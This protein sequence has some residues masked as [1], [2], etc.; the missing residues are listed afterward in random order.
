MIVREPAVAGSFYSAS[1]QRC[2]KEVEQCI[3]KELDVSALPEVIF[4]GIVP[5]AG[6]TFSGPVAGQVFAAIAAR[7]QPATF[8]VFG[9]V[10]RRMGSTAAIFSSGVWETPLGAIETDQRLAERIMSA[11]SLIDDDPYAHEME[12][13]IE[14]QVP[15]IQ[16]LFPNARLVAI[17]VQPVPEAVEV[18]RAV[19]STIKAYDADAVVV[20]STDLTHYGPRYGFAPKGV[21]EAGVRWAKE[22][23]DRRILD[24]ILAM[25]A[26]AIVPEAAEHMNACGAGAAAATV[27]ACRELGATRGYLLSHVSSYEVAR[28]LWG[29]SSTD[30]VGYA[31][32]V[33][34]S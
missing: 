19:A 6:W 9:A 28:R 17:M 27:A 14:V 1:P 34:G 23:N 21:G 18:G 8:V 2:R 13:S 7:R 29:E 20:G 4:G 16:H 15:F 33:F 25:D 11:S 10:H 3:P 5:H 32:V 24:L 22:V 30:A 26:E 12:H 31:A